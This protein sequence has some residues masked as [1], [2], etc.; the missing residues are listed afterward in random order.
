MVN[1]IVTVYI[2]LPSLSFDMQYSYSMYTHTWLNKTIIV[3]ISME[4]GSWRKMLK[5]NTLGH[6]KSKL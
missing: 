3:W 1:F 6:T 4:I 5:K 2:F